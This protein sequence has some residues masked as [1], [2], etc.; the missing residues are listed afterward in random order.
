[1]GA[2][3]F[4]FIGAGIVIILVMQ[5]LIHDTLKNILMELKKQSKKKSNQGRITMT[6]AIVCL[7]VILILVVLYGAWM[8]HNIRNQETKYP[9]ICSQPKNASRNGC[10]YLE[11]SG[12]CLCPYKGCNLQT[13]KG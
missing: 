5:F 10:N 7:S 13:R 9:Y 3:E 6:A 1:M 12:R 11:V 8:I 2:F 4:G